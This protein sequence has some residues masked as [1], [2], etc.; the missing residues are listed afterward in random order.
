MDFGFNDIDLSDFLGERQEANNGRENSHEVKTRATKTYNR[1]IFRRFSSERELEQV[2]DWNFEQTTAYHV[3][4]NGDIDSL[5]FLKFIVRQ[6][7]IEYLALSTWCMALQDIDEI[8][9]LIKLGRIR[10]ADSYVGEIFKS[11][12][13]NEYKQLAALHRR[14]GGRVAIFRNHAKVFCGFGKQFD[15]VVESS[16]NINTNPRTENTVITVDTGLALFYKEFF[17]GIVSFERNF[18][19]WKPYAVERGAQNGN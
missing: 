2:I 13:S 17:D 3:I 4:S 8:E 16:A 6:Q 12:Y 18:D 11:S 1:Q 9:R 5:S 19:D 10:R 7:A 14:Y 15:F